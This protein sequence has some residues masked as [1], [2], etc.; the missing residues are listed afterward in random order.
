MNPPR[1]SRSS[2]MAA[3]RLPTDRYASPKS[4]CARAFAGDLATT[5]RHIAS[6]LSQMEFRRSSVNARVVQTIRTKLAL[7]R[8]RHEDGTRVRAA[9]ASS[10]AATKLP[11]LA[12]YTRCSTLMSA[13]GTMVD[14]GLSNKKN[15]RIPSVQPPT[16]YNLA[17][18]IMGLRLWSGWCDHGLVRPTRDG[19]ATP[20]VASRLVSSDGHRCTFSMCP[21]QVRSMA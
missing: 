18:G 16:K 17:I 12:K 3:L 10:I 20:G 9:S 14:V 7:T 11:Q 15:Q 6:W 2:G 21:N 19:P 5:S 8:A 1:A 13:R 4:S